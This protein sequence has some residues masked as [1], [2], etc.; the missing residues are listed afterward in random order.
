MKLKSTEKPLEPPTAQQIAEAC[1][2]L[3]SKMGAH[4]SIVMISTPPQGDDSYYVSYRGRFLTV[5][6]LFELGSEIL[7]KILSHPEARNEKTKH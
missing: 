2:E 1:A 7:R 6:G 5:R 4:V 3:A